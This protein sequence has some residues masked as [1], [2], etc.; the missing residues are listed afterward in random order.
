MPRPQ[1]SIR[2]RGLVWRAGEAQSRDRHASSLVRLCGRLRDGAGIRGSA[3][4]TIVI[5]RG[6]TTKELGQLLAWSKGCPASGRGRRGWRGILVV[7]H[8]SD[9]RSWLIAA[10]MTNL[11][12]M[13]R[14]SDRGSWLEGEKVGKWIEGEL[15]I[16]PCVDERNDQRRGADGT[17]LEWFARNGA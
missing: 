7:R 12:G 16:E 10:A 15:L 4:G 5:V 13:T 1:H 17:G 9:R 8:G 14:G 3:G 6:L 2:R 11:R